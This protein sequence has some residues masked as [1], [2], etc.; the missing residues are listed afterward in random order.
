MLLFGLI[1]K[2]KLQARSKPIVNVLSNISSQHPRNNV[3]IRPI[4]EELAGFGGQFTSETSFTVS[5]EIKYKGTEIGHPR[6]RTRWD[7]KKGIFA[8]SQAAS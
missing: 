6:H 3:L 8:L 1:L 4:E 2:V 7:M 5:V